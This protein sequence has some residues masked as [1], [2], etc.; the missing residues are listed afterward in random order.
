MSHGNP[1]I[2]LTRGRFGTPASRVME[3]VRDA[4]PVARD[5]IAGATGLSV[6]TI[7]RTV[8]ALVRSG[9]LRERPD[10]APVGVNGRPGVPVEVDP[11]RFATLGFHLGRGV[12]SVAVGDLRGRVICHRTIAQPV[13]QD[14][15][16]H[17]LGRL[18][19]QL[20]GTQP[21][22]APLVAGLVAPWA[23]LGLDRDATR[24]RLH[25][26]VGLDVV[27]ADHVAAMAATE[28]LHRRHGTGG[29][30]LYIYARNTVGLAIAVDRGS[31][32]EV[33][34]T[35]SLTHFPTGSDEPCTCGR[36]G[37]LAATYSDLG[38]ARRAVATG[39]VG[40]GADIDEVVAA[41]REGSDA[42]HDLLLDR[43]RILGRVAAI[44]RDMSA[45]HRVV[46]VGQ[47]FTAYEPALKVAVEGFEAQTAL[48][49]VDVSFT[50]FGAGIQ[51][52]TACTV[53]IGPVYDDPLGLVPSAPA[54]PPRT[55]PESSATKGKIA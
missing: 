29:V 19:A 47:A 25:E 18:A 32:T 6:P 30:T 10:A 17:E 37:C 2:T 54:H 45:P 31:H 51:A 41:A 36:T 1:M 11:T 52:T 39:V 44:V 27:A 40:P 20:L 12:A 4:G 42:A 49:S 7:N 15:D 48:G 22:R 43:A 53:A 50:R 16:L 55:S 28:F 21:G 9:L 14:P 35:G 26:V 23:D 46:L 38:V 34:R 8:T 24:D 3:E 33:S 13:D 5:A